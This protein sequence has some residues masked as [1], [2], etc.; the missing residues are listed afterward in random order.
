MLWFPG[1][2]ET[3]YLYAI[4]SASLVHS[5]AR[6]CAQNLLEWCTCDQAPGPTNNRE[7]WLWGGCGDN[8]RYARKFARKFL[9]AQ[10]W[11]TDL[12]GRVD[13]HNTN[14]GIKVSKYSEE[15]VYVNKAYV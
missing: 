1:V 4:S 2:K 7:A 14:V 10:K 3:A 8:I 13:L 9:Q 12:R 15:Y 11:G 6:A 5:F